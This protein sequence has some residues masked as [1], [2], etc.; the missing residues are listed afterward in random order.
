MGTS[1]LAYDHWQLVVDL[2]HPFLEE[3]KIKIIQLGNKEDAPLNNCYMAIGQ[4][5]FNQKAYVVK[6]SLVHICP[7]NESMHVASA[8]DK[9]CVALFPSNCFPS[10]F[11][12]YWSTKKNVEIL[13]SAI[14]TKP[15]FN[16]NETPK[17][18]N[19]IT[20]ENVAKKILNFLGIF[21]F[22]PEFKTLRIGNSFKRKRIESALLLIY[23]I[24][25]S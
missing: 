11:V 17:S 20:P 1:A 3:H 6:K 7:N 14:G 24:L 4:C 15:S 5:N 13:S 23:W 21:T 8:F 18:I 22:V 25:Q 16:P 12:P 9:K 2:I 19:G 10:Q